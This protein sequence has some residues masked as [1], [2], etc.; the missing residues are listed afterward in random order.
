[1]K[2]HVWKRLLSAL[3]ILVMSL[4]AASIPVAGAADLPATWAQQDI[5]KAVS[6]GFV[7]ANLQSAYAQPI[8]RAEFCA[9]AVAFYQKMVGTISS[10]DF[11]KFEF[12]DT[13]DINVRKAA[14][15]SVVNGVGGGRFAPN[16]GITREQA[17]TMLSRLANA[18]SIP[19]PDSEA[20]FSDAVSVESW[21]YEAVGQMQAS[22]IMQGV[23]GNAFSPKGQYQRQQSIV[24]ILRLF[25]VLNPEIDPY[26]L[27][28]ALG[29]SAILAT[30]NRADPHQFGMTFRSPANAALE[31]SVLR[32]DW[33]CE[34][35]ED[36]IDT[37]SLMTDYGH[38]AS[39]A[40]AYSIV[41]SLS[42]EEYDALLVLSG[43][44][45]RYMWPLTKSIGDKWGGKQI[46][47]WDWFRMIHLAGWGY[48]AGYLELDE[49]YELMQPS[50]D[51]LHSTFSSWEEACDNYMD[52]YAWWSRTDVSQAYSEYKSRL[53]IYEGL[54]GD[55]TLFDPSVW[56]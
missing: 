3:I 15:I 33:G 37:I 16:D 14:S 36:I 9:L 5:D 31:K 40:E 7:P 1:M 56:K 13:S 53:G 35:R 29:C 43:D 24:T 38:N 12:T 50:I 54:K 42:K 26:Y 51:R 25:E 22:G 19:L 4:S 6:L 48:V 10:S 46:K 21:A 17:A 2:K 11:T 32:R 34:S 27:S 41:N 8:T 55:A 39:F 52:G 49:A 18:V 23:G 30:R 44:V 47:A 45:D 20:T 28:W